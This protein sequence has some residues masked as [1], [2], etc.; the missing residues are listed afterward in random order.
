MGNAVVVLQQQSTRQDG[1]GTYRAAFYDA[2]TGQMRATVD[3]QGTVAVETWRGRPAL[4]ARDART[5]PASGL[6][7]SREARVVTAFDEDGKQ[8]GTTDLTKD[9]LKYRESVL[10]GWVIR[11]GEGPDGKNHMWARPADATAPGKLVHTCDRPG[12]DSCTK[13][14]ASSGSASAFAAQTL[15]VTDATDPGGVKQLRAV[16][17]ATGQTRW[18]TASVQA[19][20]GAATVEQIKGKTPGRRAT[21]V[22]TVGDK[23]VLGWYGHADDATYVGGPIH[24][25]L[26]DAATGRLL[27]GGPAPVTES[28][29]GVSLYTAPGD[30]TLYLHA[31]EL[32]L[33]WDTKTGAIVWQQA[34][35]ERAARVFAAVN[36]ALYAGVDVSASMDKRAQVTES[37]VL[38]ARTKA[39]LAEKGPTREAIPQP[40]A[41]GYA[42]AQTKDRIWVFAPQPL[43]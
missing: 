37:I 32:G 17:P 18:S 13:P 4:V 36:G 8:I 23:V 3:V 24:L 40:A 14:V 10:D 29:D 30:P 19:P 22:G 34:K 27:S 38:D 7:A 26:Y 2:A 9:D 41:N 39:V 43:T 28:V 21:V 35:G 16:D 20:A 11:S 31:H 42:T 6:S 25:G 15:F 1:G 33:A 5:V 12:D